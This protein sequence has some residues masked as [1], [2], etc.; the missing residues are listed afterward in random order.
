LYSKSPHMGVLCVAGII[1]DD[2]LTDR[3]E[4]QHFEIFPEPFTAPQ[5]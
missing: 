1:D 4:L 3:A 5:T 2:R